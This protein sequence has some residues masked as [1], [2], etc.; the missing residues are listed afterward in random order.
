MSHD[1]DWAFSAFLQPGSLFRERVVKIVRMNGGVVTALDQFFVKDIQPGGKNA[2][3]SP[4]QIN[5]AGC[6][7]SSRY[8]SD[9][10]QN[11]CE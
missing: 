1:N 9:G 3:Q 4:Q 8:S 5:V 11:R 10:K 2:G 6:L 7:S